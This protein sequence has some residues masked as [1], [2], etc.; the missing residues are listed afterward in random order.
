MIVNGKFLKAGYLVCVTAKWLPDD[1]LAVY[2]SSKA[3]FVFGR[4]QRSFSV[5]NEGLKHE[6]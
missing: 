4:H 5:L 2:R 3:G 6:D 1:K